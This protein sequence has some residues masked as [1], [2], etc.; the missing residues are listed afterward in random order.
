MLYTTGGLVYEGDGMFAV[1]YGLD[2]M[3]IDQ[4]LFKYLGDLSAMILVDDVDDPT[5]CA[6]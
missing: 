2:L 5:C 6:V 3:G 1:R 4:T